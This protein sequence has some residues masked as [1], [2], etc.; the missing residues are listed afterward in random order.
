[1]WSALFIVAGVWN[2]ALATLFFPQAWYWQ[3][4]LLFDPHCLT[5]VFG[6]ALVLLPTLQPFLPPPLFTLLLSSCG[7]LLTFLRV[8]APVCKYIDYWIWVSVFYSGCLYVLHGLSFLKNK[9]SPFLS[10]R[11]VKL[12]AFLKVS[13]AALMLFVNPDGKASVRTSVGEIVF[14][15]LFVA[16]I[17]LGDKPKSSDKKLL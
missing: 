9:S 13:S 16:S 2:L 8:Y 12:F 7:F 5:A 3:H 17:T 15:A 10:K 14:A 1:M 4:G 11:Q 6:R